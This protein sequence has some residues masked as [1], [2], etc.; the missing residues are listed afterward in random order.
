M[1]QTQK[2]NPSQLT[3]ILVLQFVPVKPGG[4]EHVQPQGKFVHGAPL[5]QGFE[6]Q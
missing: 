1:D 4:H 2:I 3:S 6:K 5:V